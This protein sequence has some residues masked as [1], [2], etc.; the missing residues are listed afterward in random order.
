MMPGER[1]RVGFVFLSGAVAALALNSS[2]RL[3]LWEDRLIG[4][5]VIC[6]QV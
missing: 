3:Y 2:E 4:E 1:R 6:K 5:A